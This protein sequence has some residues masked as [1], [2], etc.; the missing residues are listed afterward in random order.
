[1][2]ILPKEPSAKVRKVSLAHTTP[3][4]SSPVT[5][6]PSA[7][8]SDLESHRQG[9]ASLIQ[10]ALAH[11]VPIAVNRGVYQYSPGDTLEAK[12]ERLTLEIENAVYNTH[13]DKKAYAKQ[14][15][16]LNFNLKQNQELCNSLLTK[17]LS[18]NSLAVMSTDD[19]ASKELKRETAEMQR[20]S[21][22]QA[23]MIS[24][25]RPRM[26][27]THKG[28]EIIEDDDIAIANDS[29]MSVSRR[30]SMLDPNADMATRSRENS[31]GNE[32]ELPDNINDY[33]SNDDIRS[34]TTQKEPLNVDT[35]QSSA[36]PAKQERKASAQGDFDINKVFSSVQSPTGPPSSLPQ[37]VRRQSGNAPP[38]N[39]P[40]FD[41][42]IDK[43]LQDE[44][45]NE[46]PPYSPAEYDSDPEIV[47]RGSV[48]M[49]SSVSF[50]VIAKHIGGADLS[51]SAARIP[52]SDLLPKD[53]RVAGRIGE[54]KAN[55]YLCSLR[56]SAPSDVVVIGITP[57]GE[58]SESSFQ[59]MFK[60]FH[61]KN[62]YGVLA[63][64]TI[65]NVRDTYLVPVEASPANLPDFITNLEGHKVPEHRESR[66]MLV[67][68]A[69]RTKWDDQANDSTQ[70]PSLQNHHQ[71]QMSMTG[72]GPAMSP[73]GAPQGPFP[74][75]NQTLASSTFAHPANS[76]P[77]D[78]ARRAQD[79]QRI[80][81]Q[82][83][84]E[85]TAARILGRFVTA[86]TAVFLLPN[87]Y[88]MRPVEWEIIRS[89]L[90]TDPKAQTD[91]PHLSAVIALRMAA[92][93]G[94]AQKQTE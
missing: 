83:V 37:N 47:W 5:D 59:E 23:I 10:K 56:Y 24:D 88:Q 79:E 14:C 76:N 12:L 48:S 62:R 66:M 53:L 31:P 36:T 4:Q 81:D 58:A 72:A 67:A 15:R 84:G 82:K 21:D 46:S 17:T 44:D 20:R 55:E 33:R 25:D 87:A 63:N 85:E 89:I 68:M 69:V 16:T 7:K 54:D 51:T 74:P 41:P 39:G 80:R 11:S 61:E 91:L 2:L 77:E 90:E 8:I 78:A 73:I 18:P 26:R 75:P 19:M 64:K 34:K 52:W 86:P 1:L 40:G 60:Y 13:P 35:N 93:G 43:M 71:R 57:V 6:V 38:A 30:R 65:V 29:T 28:D 45:G 50:P 49:D 70:S 94:V 32:V 92:D 9:A 27:R 3:Q 42:E 22:Q